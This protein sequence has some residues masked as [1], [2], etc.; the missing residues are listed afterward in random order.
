ME[1]FQI[2]SMKLS[3]YRQEIQ[4]NVKS[5]KTSL[6]SIFLLLQ[7]KKVYEFTQLESKIYRSL[8]KTLYLIRFI[9]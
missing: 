2:T 9:N 7:N 5:N 4:N 1:T 3:I 8:I 6:K